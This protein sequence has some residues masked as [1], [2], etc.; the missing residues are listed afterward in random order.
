MN[1]LCYAEFVV[2]LVKAVQELAEENQEQKN[3]IESLLK[4]IEKLELN[5]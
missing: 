1:S 4:R 5:K 3:M 2:P